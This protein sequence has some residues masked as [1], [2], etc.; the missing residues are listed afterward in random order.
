MHTR[1]YILFVVF[2]FC[3][4]CSKQRTMFTNRQKNKKAKENLDLC[5]VLF[6]LIEET[7]TQEKNKETSKTKKNIQ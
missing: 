6:A 4:V 3:S 2:F 5:C 7:E 1:L